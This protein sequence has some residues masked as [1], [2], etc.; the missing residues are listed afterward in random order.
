MVHTDIDRGGERVSEFDTPKGRPVRNALHAAMSA[1]PAQRAAAE[2]A[3]T[4]FHQG[5]W[6]ALRAEIRW[7]F[8]PPRVWLTGVVANLLLTAAWLVVQRLTAT[9]VHRAPSDYHHAG[10]YHHQLDWVILISTYFA[11]FVL[12]DVTTTN[13]LGADHHR[14][15]KGLSEGTPFWRVLLLKN[16]TLLVIVGLPTLSVAM[17]LTLWKQTPAH[18]RSDRTSVRARHQKL[19]ASRHR[20]DRLGDRHS[21]GLLVGA[22][23]RTTVQVTSLALVSDTLRRRRHRRRGQDRPGSRAVPGK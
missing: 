21:G 3:A 14:V 6:R 19:R 8:T 12:A 13:V 1:A 17:A 7:A 9:H 5:L 16:L 20:R 4:D 2:A 11:S 22:Q 10:F 15:A 18:P 23:A